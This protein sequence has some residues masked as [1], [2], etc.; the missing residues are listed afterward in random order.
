MERGHTRRL[1]ATTAE[2]DVDAVMLPGLV[3]AHAHLD[4]GR[5]ESV[6]ASGDFPS[7]LLG[8]GRA[9]GVERDPR[10]AAREQAEELALRGVVAVGDIDANL[11]AATEGRREAGLGGRSYLE[12]VGVARSSARARLAAALARVDRDGGFGSYG[13]SPHAP[14]SVHSDV[15]PEIARAARHRGLPLAMHLAESEEETRY[16]TH[17]DGPFVRF[18]ETLGRGRP[19][20]SPPG[21]RPIAYA[22]ACGLL[23]GDTLVVHGNDLDDEDLGLLAASGAALVYCH[24]THRHFERPPHRLPELL[25]AGVTVALGTDSSASNDDIDLLREMGRL[26]EDR[27]DIAPLDVL[28]AATLGG[29]RALGLPIGESTWEAGTRAHATWLVGA[30]DDVEQL[31]PTEVLGWALSPAARIACT[32][33]SGRPRHAH[34]ELSA[35]LDTLLERG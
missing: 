23:T 21:L 17:G 22:S 34:D 20:D 8:V 16:L 6:P 26:V 24:G 31:S 27:P 19:F 1:E 4:L 5:S 13:L 9:R 29:R 12:I 30:P 7:W 11:G 25:G 32:L 35:Q 15:L 14:Y 18:L 2:P 3:N 10:G 33:H 28:A